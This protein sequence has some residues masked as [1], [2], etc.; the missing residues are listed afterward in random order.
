MSRIKVFSC[1]SCGKLITERRIT[2]VG[3]CTKCGSGR[4]RSASPT[5]LAMFL[6]KIGLIR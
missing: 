4:M 3:G 1:Y 5:K 6:I 2:K